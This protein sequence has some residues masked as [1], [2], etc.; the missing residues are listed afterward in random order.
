M[1]HGTSAVL[2]IGVNIIILVTAVFMSWHATAFTWESFLF[3]WRTSGS[4]PVPLF[5]LYAIMAFGMLY[6]GFITIFKVIEYLKQVRE[7]N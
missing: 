1:L 7:G 2:G 5:S 4:L 6:L 3:G